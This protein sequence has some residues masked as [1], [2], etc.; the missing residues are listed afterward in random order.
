MGSAGAGPVRAKGSGSSEG[1]R[2]SV[3]VGSSVMVPSS[4]WSPV[5][6]IGHGPDRSLRPG[7]RLGVRLGDAPDANGYHTVRVCDGDRRRLGPASTAVATAPPST[8][9]SA[10]SVAWGPPWPARSGSSPSSSGSRSPCWPW[11]GGGAC[12]STPWPGWCWPWPSPAGWPPT[13]PSPRRPPL[14]TATWGWPWWCWGCWPSFG[15]SIWVSTTRWW[16]P[17]VSCSPAPSSPGPATPM[18][19]A[20]RRWCGPWPEWRWGWAAWWPSWPCRPTSSTPPW[21]SSSRWPW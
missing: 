3:G 19:P 1:E 18:T 15:L 21:C 8:R 12:C 11:P 7:S 9:P 4:A 5:V 14:S 6:G 13:T 20:C 2:G 16:S 17:P 10:G